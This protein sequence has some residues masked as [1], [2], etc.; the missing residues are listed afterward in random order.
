MPGKGEWHREGEE[1][2]MGMN[3]DKAGDITSID[4]WIE[5]SEHMFG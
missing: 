1:K 5:Y 2:R 4:R 3:S